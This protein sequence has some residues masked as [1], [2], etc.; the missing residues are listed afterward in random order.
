MQ[1]PCLSLIALQKTDGDT[2]SYFSTHFLDGENVLAVIKL[3]PC[4]CRGKG[5]DPL[6]PLAHEASTERPVQ[7]LLLLLCCPTELASYSNP[8]SQRGISICCFLFLSLASSYFSFIIYSEASQDHP[9]L[10]PLSLPGTD[11]IY[12]YCCPTTLKV[13]GTLSSALCLMHC[14]DSAHVS[15]SA[16][17]Q[18]PNGK[19]VVYVLEASESRL[20]QIWFNVIKFRSAEFLTP[21][22]V[23]GSASLHVASKQ[24]TRKKREGRK[25]RKKGGRRHWS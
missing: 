9:R 19:V 14:V 3:R 1:T 11:H 21:T 10:C 20:A 8:V 2:A 6:W 17:S 16:S 23:K 13:W 5:W 25:E 12:Y 7:C 18:Q 22:K 24:K 4:L 15:T